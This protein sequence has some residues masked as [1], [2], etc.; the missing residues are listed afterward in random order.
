MN[1]WP[2]SRVPSGQGCAP[3]IVSL[4]HRYRARPV[5]VSRYFQRVTSGWSSKNVGRA[6]PAYK[7]R[8]PVDPN[9]T[10]RC[11]ALARVVRFLRAKLP[12]QRVRLGQGRRDGLGALADSPL[13]GVRLAGAA[14]V[15]RR[16]VHVPAVAAVRPLHG[17]RV[18]R[19]RLARAVA[20]EPHDAVAEARR[21]TRAAVRAPRERAVALGR[22]GLLPE[23]VHEVVIERLRLGRGDGLQRHHVIAAGRRAPRALRR[24]AR[25]R[26]SAKAPPAPWRRGGP[27]G[28]PR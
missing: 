25:Y 18:R 9:R 22:A 13:I 3:G 26:L 5:G 14:E 28:T 11:S 7:S 8:E 12:A 16:A 23:Q 1:C 19:A 2:R 24:A 10:R 17:I 21:L 15:P 27:P 4:A 6:P 20:P